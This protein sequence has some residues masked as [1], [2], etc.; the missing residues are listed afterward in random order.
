MAAAATGRSLDPRG[1]T[2]SPPRSFD[3]VAGSREPCAF[4]VPSAFLVAGAEAFRTGRGGL[5]RCRAGARAYAT[6][7]FGIPAGHC[8]FRFA[9]RIPTGNRR[10]GDAWESSPAANPADSQLVWSTANLPYKDCGGSGCVCNFV[11]VISHRRLGS[12]T[13]KRSAPQQRPGSLINL[14]NGR[15]EAGGRPS[16][17]SHAG[18]S[19]SAACSS[20]GGNDSTACAT[21][22][23]GRDPAGAR[24]RRKGETTTR[25]VFAH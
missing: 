12:R 6:G 19:E 25:C 3:P 9:L 24:F 22:T 15:A 16:R 8:P 23:E 4:L 2:R 18:K 14:A 1:R 5:R 17:R 20:H 21:F 11:R 7:L 13:G 10:N